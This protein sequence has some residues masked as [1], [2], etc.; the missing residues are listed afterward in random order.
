MTS[1]DAV[2]HKIEGLRQNLERK[3]RKP[4]F[5][6]VMRTTLCGGVEIGEAPSSINGFEDSALEMSNVAALETFRTPS[7]ANTEK[8]LS[9]LGATRHP[10]DTSV[11]SRWKDDRTGTNFDAGEATKAQFVNADDLGRSSHA[12]LTCPRSEFY[13][14]D[15][16][17]KSELPSSLRVSKE[18][19]LHISNMTMAHG[20]GEIVCDDSTQL[21]VRL[22]SVL[23]RLFEERRFHQQEVDNMAEEQRRIQIDL[24]SSLKLQAK[25]KK[26]VKTVEAKLVETQQK[27]SAAAESSSGLLAK[28]KSETKQLQRQIG[29]HKRVIAQ[30]RHSLQSKEKQSDQ[31]HAKLKQ[32]VDKVSEHR[33]SAEEVFRQLHGRKARKT[34][35]EDGKIMQ[36][37]M[38]FEAERRGMTAEIEQ[39]RKQVDLAN[40]KERQVLNV[41]QGV[42]SSQSTTLEA[43]GGAHIDS[44]FPFA[45]RDIKSEEERHQKEV[46]ASKKLQQ[47]LV[48]QLRRS[49][50]ELAKERVK[51]EKLE[52]QVIDKSAE[53][54]SLPSKKEWS[55]TLREVLTLKQRVREAEELS[56][57]RRIMD[58]KSLVQRDREIHRLGL[59]SIAKLPK[60]LLIESVQDACRSLQVSDISLLMPT[61]RKVCA[62]VEST[63]AMEQFVVEVCAVCSNS[64]VLPLE[65]GD[66]NQ[67][68]NSVV[69]TLRAWADKLAQNENATD[70]WSQLCDLLR[71]HSRNSDTVFTNSPSCV[72]SRVETLLHNE[73]E[74]EQTKADLQKSTALRKSAKQHQK[75]SAE[76]TSDYNEEGLTAHAALEHIAELF[77][78]DLSRSGLLGVVASSNDL[79]RRVSEASNM[80]SSLRSVLKL[81]NSASPNR[82][83]SMVEKLVRGEASDEISRRE[84]RI[85]KSRFEQIADIVGDDSGDHESVVQSTR[86]C[87]DTANVL[88]DVVEK[89]DNWASEMKR[90]L[91][92]DDVADI[93]PAVRALQ[94]R[95]S[96]LQQS[97]LPEHFSH[98]D[99]ELEAPRRL[100]PREASMSSIASSALSPASSVSRSLDLTHSKRASALSQISEH[101]S[102]C[103]SPSDSKSKLSQSRSLNLSVNAESN[104]SSVASSPKT[105]TDSKQASSNSN[106]DSTHNSAQTS[107]F[108]STS[109][110][111]SSL[112][113]SLR[114]ASV[115][116][117][118]NTSLVSAA[119]LSRPT[120]GTATPSELRSGRVSVAEALLSHERPTSY[121]AVSASVSAKGRRKST[122]R[123]DS[124]SA[125]GLTKSD[126][127]L[128]FR[129]ER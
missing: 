26:K 112:R 79:F 127:F 22:V 73:T 90:I 122:G 117:L 9:T 120:T 3:A 96:C 54:K 75:H 98:I 48:Q 99:S 82:V 11:A 116:Q 76:S 14:E 37:L 60:T 32:V 23:Q 113:L 110:S 124:E 78:I 21:G 105:R 43:S 94:R 19:L 46:A 69:P 6:D 59:E 68:I 33:G 66:M 123:Y 87:V 18:T 103:T 31:L 1:L 84:I 27:K 25:L 114:N 62:L 71:E 16:T 108:N 5:D 102:P 126:N 118:M 49:E 10:A 104:T 40:S 44:M 12:K 65:R 63:A 34:S 91:H 61:L 51:S 106:N 67:M 72:L 119:S 36:L 101:S 55:D 97:K 77:D 7:I 13:S 109:E 115:S 95:I 85:L 86:R 47:Q 74:L 38:A 4:R 111:S 41:E 57:L 15:H 24:D 20:F 17:L 56:Q 45:W 121:D 83:V 88:E 70:T 81:D 125:F 100:P 92:V 39:L 80:L 89:L 107:A 35:S 2:T 64:S 129:S 53:L 93:A 30:L 8:L 50:K 28:H 58:T 128:L 42:E 52:K 29:Q